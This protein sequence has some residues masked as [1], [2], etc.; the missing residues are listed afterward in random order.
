MAF[1]PLARQ[2][3]C[4]ERPLPRFLIACVSGVLALTGMQPRHASAASATTAPS[5]NA[6][7]YVP[8]RHDTVRDLL[9]LAEVG[10]ND[11]VYDLG[12]GDGR[13]V[14][15]A[16]RDFGARRAVGIEADPRLVEESRK[17]A[18]QAGVTDR[19]EFIQGD[20]FTNDISAASIAVL[21]LGHGPNL[22]LRAQLVRS[23]KP[24]A[25]VVAHQFSMGEWTPDKVLDVRTVLLGMYGTR[26]MGFEHNP[27]VPDFQGQESGRDHDVVSE[28]VVPAPVAGIWHGKARVG[29][30]ERELRLTLH[31]RLSAI[32]GS[33]VFEGQTNLQGYVEADLWGDHLRCWCIPTNQVWHQSQMWFEGHA[34]GLVASEQAITAQGHSPAKPLFRIHLQQPHCRP[35]YR[36]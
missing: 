8:T 29:T 26:E 13:I 27:D 7:P 23:L 36:S 16:V 11:V 12:S 34:T 28:W 21:Y 18:A 33:F 3:E 15:A 1:Q 35:P 14:I 2:A 22:D 6:I 20:L 4:M 30:E 5:T 9:W 24:G 17:N 19:V 31:Q 25:R 32:T 10:T